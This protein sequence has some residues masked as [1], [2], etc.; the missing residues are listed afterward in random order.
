MYAKHTTVSLERTQQ[1]I[2]RCLRIYGADGF[3]VG[4]ERGIGVVRFT[5]GRLVVEFRIFLPDDESVSKTNKGYRRST[6]KVAGAREQE[7]RRL[8]RALLLAIKSKLECVESGI[9]TIEKEFLP[10]VVMGDGRVLSDHL[11]PA[12]IAAREGEPMPKLLTAS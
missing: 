6:S 11:L 12:L 9:S 4:H 8:W 10:F 3:A 2:A 5:F 7:E 1:Q